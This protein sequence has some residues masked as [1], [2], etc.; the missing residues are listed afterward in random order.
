M[1]EQDVVCAVAVFNQA[2]ADLR[3]SVGDIEES[4]DFLEGSS[5]RRN[6]PSL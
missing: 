6:P 2:L 1:T 5:H 3:L 4:G